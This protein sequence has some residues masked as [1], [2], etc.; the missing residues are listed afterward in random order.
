MQEG[1]PIVSV[2]QVEQQ[3]KAHG[4]IKEMT[5]LAPVNHEMPTSPHH[6]ALAA[7]KLKATRQRNKAN[8][9]SSTQGS[10]ILG[11]DPVVEKVSPKQK[12]P[13]RQVLMS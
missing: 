9:N 4:I 11:Q 3:A 13:V 7:T 8:T 1:G 5:F 6:K 2:Y 10:V 12:P